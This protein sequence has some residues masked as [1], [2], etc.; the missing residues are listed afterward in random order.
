LI[1]GASGGVGTFAVQIAKSFGARV[2]GVCSTR[3][4]DL[5]RSIG[6]DHVIDYTREDFTQTGQRYDV[7]LDAVGSRSLSDCRR[8]LTPRGTY[9]LVG[10]SNLGRWFGL[11]R[12]L[13]VLSLSPFVRQKMRVFLVRHN[14]EDL[15]V[16]KEL[17][18]AGKLTPVMDRRYE[19]SEVPMALQHQGEGHA[20]GKIVIAV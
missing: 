14:R 11:A 20:Q 7:M 5:V 9:V 10:V 18:E 17:V 12:Q 3:N 19:L 4:I 16:L 1:N 15:L 6:A 2:T 8:A 13:K